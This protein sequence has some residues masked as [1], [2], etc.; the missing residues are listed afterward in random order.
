M[1]T[2]SEPNSSAAADTGLYLALFSIHG[3]IRGHDLELGRDADTGGQVL[4]VLELAQALARQ[5]AVARVDLFTRRIV[6]AAV[7]D[8]YGQAEEPIGDK[9]RL[10]RLDA[11]PEGYLRKE[12]LWDHLPEFV[13]HTL[14]Y[15]RRQPR[16]PDL[17][18]GHYA[19]AGWVAAR[20]SDLIGAPM[21]FTG[22]SLGREKLRRLREAGLSAAEIESTYHISRRIAAE[23]LALAAATR[24]IASTQQE[25]DTQ[26]A[27]YRHYRPEGMEV[28]PPGVDLQRFSPPGQGHASPAWDSM[29]RFLVDPDQPPLLSISRADPRKNLPALVRAFALHPELRQQANLVLIAGQRGD[30]AEAEE[31]T[32]EVWQELLLAI[33]RYD[34]YGHVAYPK[35]IDRALIP[36]LYRE[37][38]RRGGVFVNPALTEPF[39]LTLLEAAAS[40]L[41]VVATEDGGPRDILAHCQ[42]GLLVDPLDD[43]ALADAMREALSDRHRYRQW[44]AQGLAGVK[45]HY[46]WD[47]HAA[48]LLATVQGLLPPATAPQLAEEPLLLA[49]QKTALVVIDLDV[50]L[51]VPQD[52]NLPA[53]RDWLYAHRDSVGLVLT[54]SRDWTQALRHARACQLGRS[55]AWIVDV[56]ARLFW[57]PEQGA[58]PVWR[59]HVEHDWNPSAVRRTLDE[60]AGLAFRQGDALVLRYTVIDQQTCDPMTAL[61]A[62]RESAGALLFARE[63]RAN[64]IAVQSPGSATLAVVPHRA[65]KGFA[66][67]HIANRLGVPLNQ[68][69]VVGAQVSDQIALDGLTLGVVPPAGADSLSS[70]REQPQVFFAH[71]DGAAAVLEGLKHYGLDG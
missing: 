9:V 58:D 3:L 71:A 32:R 38:A 39:G 49:S 34:L 48:R 15:L 1:N 23:E 42:N 19:D 63:L 51:A 4:Y 55:D 60:V 2:A 25:V 52:P 70:L 5:P 14:E 26:Y 18:H 54:S 53:L 7:D 37:A 44:A 27:R 64:L 30:L 24:V 69:M 68:V 21:L 8:G 6:S 50:V 13:D 65:R 12:L 62:A 45:R 22:H 59:D 16:L 57:R 46:S 61:E 41:P 10:I 20:L 28:I 36:D 29:R 66:L 17:L 43:Q 33:D 56:G 40:G 35:G 31:A 47:G 67:R 11:G